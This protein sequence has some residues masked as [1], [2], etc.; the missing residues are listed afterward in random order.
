MEDLFNALTEMQDLISE[1]NRA[2][3]CYYQNDDPIMTDKQYDDRYDRLLELEK[4]T[5][6]TLVNS[7]TRKV[8]G[9]VLDSLEKVQHSKPMLSADKTK[10]IEVIRKFVIGHA[11]VASWKLDGLTI[12]L[13]YKKGI[14]EKAITRGASGIMGEDVT[15]TI[16]TCKNVPMKLKYPVDVEVRGECIIAWDDFNRINEGLERPYSHPRNLAAGTVRQL[17]TSVAKGRCLLFKAFELVQDDYD[18]KDTMDILESYYYMS[19]LG[20]DVVEHHVI[21]ENI[22]DE[23]VAKFV[24]EQ[25]QY[26]VDGIIVKYNNYLYGKALGT[27][28]HHPLDIIA[29]KWKDELYETTLRNV[30]WNTSKT[31]L[32]NPVAVFDPVDLDG[33]ITTRATLHNISYIE[34]L[35]L[36][37][38]DTIQVYRANKVIPK[39][40]CSLEKT[41]NI[42][43]PEVCPCCGQS[44]VIHEENESKML[45][46][47]NPHC[48]AKLS[49]KL[50]FFAG[51][52]GLDIKGLSK[53][54]IEKLIDHE[55]LDSYK[56][57]YHLREHFRALLR[58]EGLGR[59]S[60]ENLLEA[61]E[62]S[63][64][65]TIEKFIC[66]LSIPLIGSTA[67]KDIAKYCQGSIVE[68]ARIA[69]NSPGELTRIDGIGDSVVAS[70]S[71]WWQEN[72]E[73]FNELIQEFNF[74]VNDSDES[75]TDL[76]DKVFV[77]TGTLEH[78]QNR[79]EL[80]KAIESKGGKVS[81]SVSAKTSYLIN[82][83]KES[84]SSKNQ[85]AQSLGIPIITEEEFIQMIS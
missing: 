18:K 36:G 12:V 63:R 52:S 53:A 28:A 11:C 61:I 64:N 21:D 83:D 56:S 38:G 49:S 77:I 7:P 40:H 2:A 8:L 23:V 14:L 45:Y 6:I 85:K 5:E 9:Y 74:S 73:M 35:Q 19:C 22:F 75:G 67:S 55:L 42:V 44:T 82:N 68:F 43:I 72:C 27:T 34:N 79:A 84:S 48:D 70:L 24:P 46:C 20:L 80:I 4:E 69:E 51:K 13:R 17:D 65:A 29:L 31:G 54:T 81:G 58:I 71:N 47:D 50:T 59:K 1:L 78:Y 57:I 39:V 62:S 10:D 60:I 32:I 16:Q 41:N 26:P 76:L 33:G 30:E 66:A 37:I 25:Y 3:Y 15:H